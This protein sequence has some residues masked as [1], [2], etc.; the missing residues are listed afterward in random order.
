MEVAGNLVAAIIPPPYQ[1]GAEEA[2]RDNQARQQIPEPKESEASQR[3]NQAADQKGS[4]TGANSQLRAQG[5]ALT[6]ARTEQNQASRQGSGESHNSSA[7]NANTGS[8]KEAVNSSSSDKASQ[9]ALEMTQAASTAA[10]QQNAVH[11]AAG[12]AAQSSHAPGQAA[13][14]TPR[15]NRDQ[16]EVREEK[17]QGAFFQASEDGSVNK[18][19]AVRGSAIAKVYNSIMPREPRGQTIQFYL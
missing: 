10:A 6:S 14:Q 12:A 4:T 17:K 19:M 11:T 1:L 3:N 7:N 16:K 8:S 13:A 9:S 15:E 2:K 18:E 5:E